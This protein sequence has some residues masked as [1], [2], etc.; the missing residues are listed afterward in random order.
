MNL[1]VYD[2]AVPYNDRSEILYYSLKSNL[3][4][5]W[6]DHVYHDY[7]QVNLFSKWT[8][9]E[10]VESTLWKYIEEC[11]NLTPW[12]T[13]S[14]FK[15]CVLNLFDQTTFIL[16]IVTVVSSCFGTI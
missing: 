7:S 6:Q 4:L 12:F 2:D 5:G 16:F 9:D 8:K 3:S 11:I 14:E 15:R 1:T 13:K 10:L